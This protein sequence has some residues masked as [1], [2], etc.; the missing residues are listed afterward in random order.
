MSLLHYRRV[1]ETCRP[2]VLATDLIVEDLDL[3]PLGVSI[4]P[5]SRR[6]PQHRRHQ[7]FV[8]LIRQ[9]DELTFGPVGMPMPQWVF[10]DCAVMP[11]AVFGFA[12]PASTLEPWVRHCLKVPKDYDGDVPLSTFIA[13]PMLVPDT[14]L[15]YSL[16][17]VN[18]V[19]PGAAPEGLQ[20]L[21]MILGLAMF[22]AR[23][24]YG[25]TQWRASKLRVLSQLGPLDVITAYTPAHSMPRTLTF[26]TAITDDGTAAVLAGADTSP[27]SPLATHLLD[28]DDEAMLRRLQL[29]VEAGVRWRIVG[30]PLIRGAAT[31]VPLRREDARGGASW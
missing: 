12:Q 13:I 15:T 7:T 18:Q 26:H 4:P 9:L 8:D 22:R 19:A 3:A 24:L 27:S 10:Y 5:E 16:C 21:T 14:W 2:F 17:D 11:G 23:N 20:Q 29:E 6:N 25:T 30:P 31:Q 1:V 28:V